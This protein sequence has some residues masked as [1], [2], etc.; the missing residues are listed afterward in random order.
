M[1]LIVI[2]DNSEKWSGQTHESLGDLKSQLQPRILRA[3]QG[4]LW[5]DLNIGHSITRPLSWFSGSVLTLH[6]LS[7]WSKVILYFASIFT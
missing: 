3:D 5:Y 6:C 2:R 1:A 4:G 7:V